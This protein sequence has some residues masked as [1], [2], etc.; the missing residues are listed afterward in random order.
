MADDTRYA[1]AVARIRGLETGL[2]D[3]QWI[4]RLLVED[5]EGVL[6]V[7]AD[8]AF[9]EAIA[10]I[11]RPEDLEEGLVRARAETL[12]T[13]S[14]LSPEPALIDLF[15]V[16]WDFRNLRSLIKASLLKPSE[17]G[18]G[19]SGREIGL[20]DGVGTI[21]LQVLQK[22]V[23][24]GDYVALP[25]VLADV[26]RAAADVF[27]DSGEM[28]RVDREFDLAMWAHL[29][30]VASENGSEFLTEYFRVEIDLLNVRTFI[31]VKEAGLDRTDLLRVF[32]PGGT[33][34]LSFLEAHLGEPVDAFARSLEYGRYGALAPIFH[35]WTGEK[36]HMLELACDDILLNCVERAKTIAYGIEPLVAFILVRQMEIKLVRAAV[37]AKLDG[38]SRDELEGRLRAVHV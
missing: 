13:V 9:Q 8:S 6:S 35:E 24:D 19:P 16:R 15:R 12:S 31:R 27:R 32:V 37:A 28:A 18:V 7:L 22:A 14:A 33:L 38:I 20:T 5:A 21:D 2:L 3:R 11:D 30:T 26:A 25:A 29:L 34:D 4:E 23:Q 1:Y 17:E 10:D 36:A